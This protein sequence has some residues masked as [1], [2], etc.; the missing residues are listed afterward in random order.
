MSDH[1]TDVT[2]G[3]DAYAAGRDATIYT[4]NFNNDNAHIGVQAA[5]VSGDLVIYSQDSE[6]AR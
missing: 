6:A 5:N 3:R 1:Q 2:A 4:F